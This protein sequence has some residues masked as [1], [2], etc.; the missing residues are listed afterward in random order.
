LAGR[1]LAS[2]GVAEAAFNA[3]TQRRGNHHVMM[4]GTFANLRTKNLLV[5]EKDGGWTRKFPEGVEM[6]VYDTAMAYGRE[7][8]PAI[9]LAGKDYGMGSS[10]DWAAKGPAL[11]GVR[12]VVAESFER[13]HRSNLIGMG[14]LPLIFPKGTGWRALGLDGSERFTFRN[15]P[16]G[17]EAGAPVEVDAQQSNGRTTHFQAK[18]AVVDPSETELLKGGGIFGKVYRNLLQA[19][20]TTQDRAPGRRTAGP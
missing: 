19:G 5:P 11:L 4:R 12:I 3:Y 10:R 20:Q 14:I 18:V 8:T 2:Q 9:V 17:V 1:F 15:L 13:I 6:P 16:A 7:G